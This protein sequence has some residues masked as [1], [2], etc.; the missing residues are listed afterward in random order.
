MQKTI[1]ASVI[2]LA[3]S[4]CDSD[5]GV[6]LAADGTVIS[7]DGA[8]TTE[9]TGE[10]TTAAADGDDGILVGTESGTGENDPGSDSADDDSIVTVGT[11]GD[12]D[13][14]GSTDGG[15]TGSGGTNADG[16]SGDSTGSDGETSDSTDEDKYET[17][18]DAADTD[19]KPDDDSGS[20]TSDG[21]EVN[22]D[23]GSATSDGGEV[24]DDSGSATSDGGE[25]TDDSGSATS[26]GGQVSDDSGSA[27]SDGGS[28]DDAG[29][30]ETTAD[31]GGSNDGGTF[32]SDQ[33]GGSVIRV[34]S[35]VSGDQ[36]NICT[37]LNEQNNFSDTRVGD[38][39]LHNN[40]WR[41][42]RAFPDYQWEQCIYT[43]TNGAVAGWFYDWGP[44][45]PNI[46]GAAS[47]SGDFYVRSYPELIYGVKDEFRTSAPQSETGFP[48]HLSDLPN[49]S[50]DYSYAGPQYGDGRVVDASNN[51]RFPNGTTING[52]RN[53]AIESFLY[54]PNSAGECSTDIV[55]RNGGSN[56]TFEIMVWLDAGAERLPAGPSDFVTNVTIRGDAY[57]VYT[58]ASDPRYI[59]FVAQNPQTSGQLIWNDFTDW[60][61]TYSHQVEEQFG[62]RSNSHQIQQDWCVANIIVGT[63]IFWGSGNLDIYDWTITQRQP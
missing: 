29:G 26:D 21:G 24:N 41:P 39:I 3:L 34:S 48:V 58:K 12:S 45:I 49:I 16:S 7:D 15:S 32:E 28:N 19:V 44:G 62:A 27:T 55:T 13:D 56:H 35:L 31:N 54:E 40:A 11:G 53:V 60:A 5:E 23:S 57:K 25:V 50:I 51:P 14:T 4:A 30:S 18:D 43:N 17:D 2:V 59:A 20:A 38:F 61:S 47:A 10:G 33:V 6:Q 42:W 63:E 36:R 52:E 1:L 37:T 9:A 8:T 22:D 46:N